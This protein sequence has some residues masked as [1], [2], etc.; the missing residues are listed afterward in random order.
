MVEAAVTQPYHVDSY[1]QNGT[2]IVADFL[3]TPGYGTCPADVEE[4]F[5]RFC[6]S[7]A[8]TLLARQDD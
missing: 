5:D 8:T 3:I 2:H 4:A 7:M 1:H 6:E